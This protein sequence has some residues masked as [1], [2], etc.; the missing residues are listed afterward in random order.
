M[1]TDP[2]QGLSADG[3]MRAAQVWHCKDGKH[4]TNMHKCWD[5]HN[6]GGRRRYPYKFNKRTQMW[7]IRY[8]PQMC[9]SHLNCPEK[10]DCMF[11]HN[12]TELRFH[13]ANFRRQECMLERE[14]GQWCGR[15]FCTFYHNE[16]EK[17]TAQIDGI[18]F[19]D[20][21]IEFIHFPKYINF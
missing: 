10:D 21:D 15:P 12:K 7:E 1:A 6:K 5:A 17:R 2:F 19:E 14:P 13:P 9:K 4:C 16:K 18:S 3:I 20:S 8:L 11:A